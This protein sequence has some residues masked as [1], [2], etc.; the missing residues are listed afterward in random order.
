MTVFRWRAYYLSEILFQ[1]REFRQ[2]RAYGV[3][4]A[5]IQRVMTIAR[6]AV[7]RAAPESKISSQASFGPT[8]LRT[9]IVES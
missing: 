1:P 3:S 5:V 6:K 9:Q 8:A 7:L 2:L 4:I